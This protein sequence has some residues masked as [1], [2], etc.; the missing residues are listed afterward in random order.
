MWESVWA[1]ELLVA[2]VVWL[3]SVDEAVSGGGKA[4]RLATSTSDGAVLCAISDATMTMSTADLLTHVGEHISP[5]VVCARHCT[6]HAAC[7]SFNY[8]SNVGSCEFYDHAPTHCQSTVPHCHYFQVNKEN[9]L[10]SIVT[11]FIREFVR[12]HYCAL[13]SCSKFANDCTVVSREFV[14]CCQQTKQV[15]APRAARRWPRQWKFF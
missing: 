12:A 15:I 13:L 2:V 7:H 9:K 4:F 8:S 1:V 3:S 5:Q 6:S 14:N 10:E 11:T